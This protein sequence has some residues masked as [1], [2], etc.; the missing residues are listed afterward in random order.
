MA[1][2]GDAIAVLE[3]AGITAG[4]PGVVTGDT[5]VKSFSDQLTTAVGLHRAWNRAP[6][7][8]A[9]AAPPVLTS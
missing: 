7:I 1:A 2:W 4:S 6:D 9:S 8:M 3:G 5:A